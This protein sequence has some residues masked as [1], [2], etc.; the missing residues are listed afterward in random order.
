MPTR[1]DILEAAL[2]QTQCRECGFDGC[3]PYAEALD[4]GTAAHTL[5]RPGGARVVADLSRLLGLPEAPPA[6]PQEPPL[7]ARIREDDC[8]GCA[9]CLKACPTDCIIGAPK[10]MHT[11]VAADCTGCRLCL[12]PCPVA[13]ID[14]VPAPWP[15]AANGAQEKARAEQVGAL[16]AARNARLAAAKA[17]RLAAFGNEK[18]RP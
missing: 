11:V 2:A 12:A 16:V 18:S 7:V 15:P 13:Y 17:E 9:L 14:I 1:V 6:K 3:R 4:K 5:C 8:I 10:Q